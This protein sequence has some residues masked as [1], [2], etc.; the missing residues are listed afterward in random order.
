MLKKIQFQ[1]NAE[2]LD[3]VDM[4]KYDD[5]V[6]DSNTWIWLVENKN[7]V[8]LLVKIDNT[9][10]IWKWMLTKI[11]VHLLKLWQIRS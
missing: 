9:S 3:T 5:D 4:E 10:M 7:T 11:P 6:S 8:I 2:W 1:H